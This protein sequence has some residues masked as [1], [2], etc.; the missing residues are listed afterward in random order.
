MESPPRVS[1]ALYHI[2]VVVLLF[3]VLANVLANL[4]VFGGLREVEPP[5]EGPLVSIL[6]PARNE[7]RNIEECVR[8]LLLQDYPACELI[9]L[10]DH[11]EDRTAEIVEELIG[12]MRSRRV[13]ARLIRS[14]ELPVGWTGKNWACHQLAEAANGDFLFFTDADTVHEPG[15]VSAAVDYACRKNAGLVSAWPRMITE[16][17]GE[18]LIVPLILVVG[19]GFCPLWLQRLIQY[20]REQA[21]PQMMRR[22]GAANGQFMFFSRDC[23]VGIG[24]HAAVRSNVV[25]DVALGREVAARVGQGMRLFNCDALKFSTV[26]MYRSFEETWNG[27]TKNMRAV[28]EDQGVM[29]WVFGV[30]QWACLFAPFLFI[31]TAPKTVWQVVATQVVVIYLIRAILAARFKTNWLSV[32]LHPLG[33]F[34]TLLIGFNSW[35][36]TV[37]KG[38]EWKGRI[39]KPLENA[40]GE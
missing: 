39:Y 35:R 10:D 18:K 34:L 12:Q 25:E 14:E 7:E 16:T 5:A 1:M 36:K 24:G 40:P 17:L 29:F 28:F 15:T 3:F 22:F 23:Y 11:S 20:R 9:I 13:E 6:V 21:D 33:I 27:F 32:L 38:V 30:V 2:L 4:A 8:S 19:F 31:F 26:R 37:G